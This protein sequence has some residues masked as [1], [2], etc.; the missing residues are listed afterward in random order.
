[1]K[2][3]DL[4]R[5]KVTSSW[6]SPQERAWVGVIVG[7]DH[8]RPIVMWNKRFHEE[9]EYRSQLEVISEAR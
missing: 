8:A 1:M 7:W 3:G 2:V 4:V 9:V 5:L 6:L